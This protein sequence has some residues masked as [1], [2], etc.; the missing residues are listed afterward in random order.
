M[1]KRKKAAPTAPRTL[2][3][4][5]DPYRAELIRAGKL[6]ED[7]KHDEAEAIWR[8]YLESCPEDPDVCFNV[9]V[10]IMRRA[11]SPA[12][13]F[14]AAQ[15]FERVVQS[16]H[17]EIERKADAMNNMGLMME[18]CG[19]TEKAATAYAFA[20]KMFPAHKAARVNLGDA[21]RFMGDF[22]GARGEY[23][24]V[25]DQDPESPEAHFCA[26]MIALLFG[27]WERGWR[28]YRWRYKAPSFKA[29]PLSFGIPL[30]NGEP[31]DGKTIL[32]CE[33]QGY[34]DTF[35]FS[36]YFYEVKRQWPHARVLFRCQPSLH[37]VISGTWGL[38]EIVSTEGDMPFADYV[39]P[40]LDAPGLCGMKS[41]ADIPPAHC[42]RTMPSWAPW[43]LQVGNVLRKRVALVWA[44][45]P[46]HGKDKARSIPAKLYQPLIDAHPECDFFSLQC[47]PAQPEVAELRGVTDLAPEVR[48]WTDTAQ[49][50][51]CMDLL[52]SVDTAVIHLAGAMGAHAW[53]LCP[54]SPDFRWQLTR[55]DSPWYPKMRL[56]RQTDRNDWQTPIQRITDA[57]TTF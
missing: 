6:G 52:I 5:R 25:L 51:A 32:F 39:C 48:N 10:C 50:L 41:E 43:S 54:T 4:S 56:F 55:E 29:K 45:S 19:E 37:A 14:E 42:I 46:M 8:T 34:G 26:G 17:A 1:S 22:A 28:E 7:G 57:L 27:E 21:K 44:G 11:G 31:L 49:M 35:M 12:L 30:W 40:L 2:T 15:F 33:E 47:G 23:D 18:R 53:M 9:G 36:R 38:D 16:P 13:R 20:L 3:Q 24:A